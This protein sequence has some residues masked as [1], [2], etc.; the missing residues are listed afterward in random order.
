HSL[1]G[2]SSAGFPNG[3]VPTPTN[4]IP[5]LVLAWLRDAAV[6]ERAQALEPVQVAQEVSLVAALQSS[7]RATLARRGVVVE[8][9]PTSNLLIRHLGAL[10]SHPL[11]RLCPP[12]QGRPQADAIRVCIGS[13]DPITFATRLPEE[14]QLLSDAM[15][16]G[17]LSIHE[18]DEWLDRAR[19]TGIA[20]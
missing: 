13:D 12:H 16:D 6:F 1:S 20:A 4:G 11:W 7:V 19:A 5:T 9:N 15:V 10:T 8:I 17:G 3:P 14:Y 2:L 18:A